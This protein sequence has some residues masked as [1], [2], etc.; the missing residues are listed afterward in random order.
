MFKSLLSLG[1]G[2]DRGYMSPSSFALVHGS[3][4][5]PQISTNF[6]WN[7]IILRTII[8]ADT[9]RDLILSVGPV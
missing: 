1:G 2:T 5:L 8:S 7:C 4:I 9:V 3:V 6:S